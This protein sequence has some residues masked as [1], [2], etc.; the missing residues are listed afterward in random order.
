MSFVRD[1]KCQCL[2]YLNAVVV[3]GDGR[4]VVILPIEIV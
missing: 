4:I 1:A 2:R 3:G